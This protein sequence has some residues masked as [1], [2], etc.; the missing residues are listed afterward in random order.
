MFMGGQ[1]GYG[2]WM[3]HQSL[4]P[5]MYVERD[6]ESGFGGRLDDIIN[7]KNRTNFKKVRVG[8]ARYIS[9]TI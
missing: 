9:S 3:K 4:P 1:H 2:Q 5:Y 6:I 7:K 8:N